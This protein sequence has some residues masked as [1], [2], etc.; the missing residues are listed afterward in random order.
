[1][2]RLVCVLALVMGTGALAQQGGA[3]GAKKLASAYRQLRDELDPLAKVTE[4]YEKDQLT[5]NNA[6]KSGLLTQAYHTELMGRLT[7]R[8]NE[9]RDPIRR[10][11]SA[12]AAPPTM[13]KTR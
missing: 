3:D 7:K 13:A 2:K 6:L 5:L 9:A 8:Y 1:M 11:S 4:D 10:F 12:A